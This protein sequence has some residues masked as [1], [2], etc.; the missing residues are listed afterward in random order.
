MFFIF[1]INSEQKEIGSFG[2][3]ICGLCGSYGRYQVTVT[4]LCLSL[5]FIPVLKWG[6]RYYAEST[7]CHS[8]YELS[9]QAGRRLR[10]GEQ[11]E[12]H[13]EDLTL[14]RR[15]NGGYGR[16]R[17]EQTEQTDRESFRYCPSCG[18]EAEEDFM[19]CPRCGSRL[20]K[21]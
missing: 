2:P 16:D 10:R 19:F 11:T 18:Y 6:R 15:G 8:L 7:C 17:K 12:I 1:G 14:I 9:P 13:P 20:K 5:F 4:Y 3:V 21:R